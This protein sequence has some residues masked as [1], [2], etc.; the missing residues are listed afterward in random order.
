ML[1]K[2]TKEEEEKQQWDHFTEVNELVSFYRSVSTILCPLSNWQPTDSVWF[3]IR[4]IWLATFF[5]YETK[6][7]YAFSMCFLYRLIF[8]T[9]TVLALAS[10]NCLTCCQLPQD[11][12]EERNHDWRPPSPCLYLHLIKKCSF[13]EKIMINTKYFVFL[14]STVK[15]FIV[16]R[17]ITI[18]FIFRSMTWR[19]WLQQHTT[20][21]RNK[22]FSLSELLH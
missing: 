10:T 12:K 22:I 8:L 1:E 9:A 19:I 15:P 18:F 16:E 2:W 6:I 14:F 20:L 17:R 21:E 3:L 5:L 11:K 4:C 7:K 13:G